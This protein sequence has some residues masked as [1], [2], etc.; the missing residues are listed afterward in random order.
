LWGYSGFVIK[1]FQRESFETIFKILK[2]IG[3]KK[4]LLGPLHEN[5]IIKYSDSFNFFP[6]YFRQIAGAPFLECT[7]NQDEYRR[8]NSKNFRNIDRRF[9]NLK[10]LGRVQI[11]TLQ[12]A[13]DESKIKKAI[14]TYIEIHKQEWPLSKFNNKDMV[15]F[16]IS[17]AFK[18]FH[19]HLDFKMLYLGDEVIAVHYGFKHCNRYYYFGP[20]YNKNYHTYSPGKILLSTII[21]DCFDSKLLLDFQ[22]AEDS[23][24]LQ[25]T[26]SIAKRFIFELKL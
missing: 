10:E 12:N 6:G 14:L 17:L 18:T 1:D 16:F 7:S 5:L 15:E 20:A 25:Y 23:Y 13:L 22:N 8:R 24:K 2:S 11:L 3:V 4:L 26:N 19:N 21:S 9:R